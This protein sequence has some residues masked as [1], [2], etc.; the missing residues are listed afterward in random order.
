[1]KKNS[2]WERLVG[3]SRSTILRA[4]FPWRRLSSSFRPLP[5]CLIIGAQ[6]GGTSSLHHIL[7]QHRRIAAS[8]PK[9]V[10]FF[11][12]NHSF[13]LEWY[14]SAFPLRRGAVGLESTAGYLMHPHVPERV[15]K[16]L[17]GV[18]LIAL[19]RDPVARAYSNWQH[20]TRRGD[21][22]LP[23]EEAIDREAERTEAA[24][25]RL[26]A[27]PATDAR[28]E[29]RHSY[30]R[31]GQYAEQLERWYRIFPR[32]DILVLRSE[33]FFAEPRRIAD[34]AIA[35]LGLEPFAGVDVSARNTGGGYGALE[36]RLAE[37]LRRYFAPHNRRL[38]DLLGS[39]L[40][41]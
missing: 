1:M 5:G 37:R 16:D 3:R 2:F 30:L 27:D 12:D 21:E 22:D 11:S 18:K 31:R 26:L 41:W 34:L 39:D 36:P 14:R 10:H 40:G 9:E 33:D 28:R 25:V 17:P 7:G 19:L 13:G 8:N 38:Y 32:E 29:L 6:K 20:T 35:W 23:F 15:R 24:W 4:S